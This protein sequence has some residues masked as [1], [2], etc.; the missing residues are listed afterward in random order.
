VA[1]GR[2]LFKDSASCA[3]SVLCSQSQGPSFPYRGAVDLP[4]A[5]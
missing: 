3:P 2:H 1:P 5:P 4:P